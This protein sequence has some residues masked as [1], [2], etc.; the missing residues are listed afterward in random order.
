MIFSYNIDMFT[1]Y[2]KCQFKTLNVCRAFELQSSS[3]GNMK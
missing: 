1:D 3:G 2:K